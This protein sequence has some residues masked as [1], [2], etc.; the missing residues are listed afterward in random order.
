MFGLK[1][2]PRVENCTNPLFWEK[3]V[4]LFRAI[5]IISWGR[6]NQFKIPDT[7]INLS[8]SIYLMW[9]IFNQWLF[10]SVLVAI[11]ILNIWGLGLQKIFIILHIVFIYFFIQCFGS[12]WI[13]LDRFGSLWIALDHFGSLWITL[14]QFWW[15][16]INSNQFYSNSINLGSIP[17]NLHQFQWI[18]SEL[19]NLFDSF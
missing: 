1:N 3:E 16:L 9:I 10:H 6:A 19:H 17:I 18:I 13:T 14:D 8:W 4:V 5:M 7:N 15:I 11:L 2:I 12:L